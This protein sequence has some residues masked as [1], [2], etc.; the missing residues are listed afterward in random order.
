MIIDIWLIFVILLGLA[1]GSFLN[2]CIYRLPKGLS[3]VYPPSSCPKCGKKLSLLDL[4]PVVGYVLLLGRCRNCKEEISFVYPLVE[5]LT[6]I[7]FALL[8]I[9][10]SFSLD[11]L[12]YAIFASLLIVISFID[13]ET[14]EI[15]EV[16]IWIGCAFGILFSVLR[17]DI[18]DSFIGAALG[19]S[20]IY[21]I[22][23]AAA[24]VLKREAMG[25]GDALLALMI[26]ATLGGL[27]V[28]VSL[29]FAFLVGGVIA[30][31]LLL[32]KKKNIGEEVPL[33]PMMAAGAMMFIF[34]GKVFVDWYYTVVRPF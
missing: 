31:V 3:I 34:C 17:A 33:G 21:L 4:I 1:V 6:A 10:F 13:I 30:V 26:G 24:W 20:L 18:V 28:L 29:Y 14:M 8:Y 5:M 2:V 25:E 22:S 23:K 27:G 9:K 19:F 12:F 7:F 15:P 16:L 32:L 11:L